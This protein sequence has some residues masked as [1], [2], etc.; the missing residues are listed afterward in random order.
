MEFVLPGPPHPVE[1]VGVDH[2][3]LEGLLEGPPQQGVVVDDRVGHHPVRK[4]LLVEAL[5]VL[6]LQVFHGELGPGFKVPADLPLHHGAVA[7]DGALLQ[8]RLHPL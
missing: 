7:V 2:L 8:L 1:R 6:G 4:E 3:V 5:D